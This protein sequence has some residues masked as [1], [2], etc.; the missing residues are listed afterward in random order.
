[1]NRWRQNMNKKS[2]HSWDSK[3]IYQ[4]HTHYYQRATEKIIN[5]DQ[6][7]RKLMIRKEYGLE[8]PYHGS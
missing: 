7:T 5:Y 1:M 3:K 6:D 8:C 4:K 2:H